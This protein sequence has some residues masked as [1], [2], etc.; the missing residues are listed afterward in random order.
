M[1]F[2]AYIFFFQEIHQGL[3]DSYVTEKAV[4]VV[5]LTTIHLIFPK[6]TV[7]YCVTIELLVNTAPRP[8][9]SPHMWV[10]TGAKLAPDFIL[11]FPSIALRSFITD[12]FLRYA[13]RKLS[14]FPMARALEAPGRTLFLHWGSE[15]KTKRN[16]CCP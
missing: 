6:E 12:Q 16:T 7:P 5:M 13:D 3:N 15:K 11:I 1:D 9:A 8:L 4:T 10:R 14:C 2:Y